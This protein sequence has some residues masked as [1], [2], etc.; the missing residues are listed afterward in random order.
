MTKMALLD[1]LKN[2]FLA[3]VGA[4]LAK[5]EGARLSTLQTR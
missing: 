3:V 5:R 2:A 4:W 1:L